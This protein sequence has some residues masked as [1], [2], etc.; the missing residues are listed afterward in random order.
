MARAALVGLELK[1]S[2]VVV[3]AT[4]FP[5]WRYCM[6]D[7]F[8]VLHLWPASLAFRTHRE[9]KGKVASL[10]EAYTMVLE[11]AEALATGGVR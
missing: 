6:A 4:R 8:T 9:R 2:T 1:V 3:G 5:H 7:G 10:E 11:L